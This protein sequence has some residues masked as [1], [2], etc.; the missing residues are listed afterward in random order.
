MCLVAQPVIASPSPPVILTLNEVKGKN[1]TW[2]KIDSAWQSYHTSPQDRHGANAP[3]DDR[4]E[5]QIATAV[6]SFHSGCL[7]MTFNK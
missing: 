5:T 4:I 1:L 7:A 3:R 6:P 2:L